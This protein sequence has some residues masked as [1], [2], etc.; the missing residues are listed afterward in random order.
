MIESLLLPFRRFAMWF[1]W[2]VP[3]GNAAPKIFEFAIGSKGHR[4]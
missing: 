4:K 3:L 2:N 1:V